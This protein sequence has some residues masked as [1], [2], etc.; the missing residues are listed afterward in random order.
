M[1]LL[2]LRYGDRVQRTRAA[3]DFAEENDMSICKA[4]HQ[5]DIGLF[6]DEYP[7]WELGSPHRAIILHKMF[8]HA[9]DRG[10]KVAEQMVHQ[11]CQ[12]SVYDPGSKADQSAMELVGYHMSQREMR[13]IYQSIYL[14]QRAPGLPPCGAQSRRKAIQDILSSLKGRLQRCGCSTTVRNLESQEQQVGLN[15]HGSYEEALR[16]AH[17]RALNTAEAHTSDIERLGWQRR[18]RSWSHSR[19]C[20]QSRSHSRTRSWSRS[21]S[22]AQ[23][24]HH[25]QGNL[26]NVHPMSPDGPP[27]GRRVTFRNPEA[28]MSSRR[29]TKNYSTEP[30]VSNVE[31]WLE[32]QANH[33]GTPAWWTKLQAIPGIRDPWKLA[34]KIGASVYIPEVRMRTLLEP[35]YTVPPAPRSLD[36]NA[37][38]WDDLSYEDV[39]QKLAL[40]M[41]A[42]TRSLQY[43][44]EKQSLPRSWNLCPLAESVVELWEAVKEYITFNLQDVIWGLGTDEEPKA[45]IFSWVLSSLNEDQEA[46]RATTHTTGTAAERDMADHTASPARTKMENPCLLFVMASVVQLNLGPGVDTIGRSTAVENAFQNPQMVATFSIPSRAVCYGDTTIKE[47]DE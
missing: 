2:S 5:I 43:W 21:H 34:W 29:D 27:P 26:Q 4:E 19:N 18:G 28:E 9:T 6:L 44:A 16:V 11:H 32:W 36:R 38:L 39:W 17:Q 33:L 22:R 31:T 47:L 14:L 23:S 12:S 42:Y 20:S 46:G 45:T 13:D 40:L 15:W 25:S 10:W 24:Q 35:Q 30:S 41:I 1:T 7:R 8:L 3:W 37:F